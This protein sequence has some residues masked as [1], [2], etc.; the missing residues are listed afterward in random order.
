M[1]DQVAATSYPIRP[2]LR[3]G[4]S[5]AGWCWQIYHVNDL[6]LPAVMRTAVL[7]MRATQVLTP[8]NAIS[9]L[10]GFERLQPHHE[11]ESTMLASWSGQPRS[12]WYAWSRYPRFCPLCM[13]EEECHLLY[14][15]LPLV[16]ACAAHKCLLTTMCHLCKTTW[17]WPNKKRGWR[18]WCGARIAQSPARAAPLLE[19]H[20]SRVLC[21][22]TDALVPKA[23]Q[24]ASSGS[25]HVGTQYRTRDVYEALEWLLKVRRVLTDRI[26]YSSARTWPLTMRL[27]ART[28]PD[29]WEKR[30][31]ARLPYAIDQKARQTLRWFF[32]GATSTLVDLQN[33]DRWRYVNRL[34]NEL[35]SQRNPMLEPILSAVERTQKENFARMP[36]EKTMLFNPRLNR[37]QRNK[38]LAE[39]SA[40]LQTLIE[41]E[42]SGAP[43]EQPDKQTTSGPRG[44]ARSDHCAEEG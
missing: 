16:S 7:G 18:C 31:L 30:L 6:D 24:V 37:D 25:T 29:S 33:V 26:Y 41:S 23:V 10:I 3:D 28:V 12:R 40:W 34:L 4:E 20:F 5:L 22:A 44:N 1:T 27:D 17:K 32:K 39:L 21:N 14:W 9:R 36:G 8:E 13:A 2:V 35:S 15:D 11:R 38:R 43:T 42:C 19:V